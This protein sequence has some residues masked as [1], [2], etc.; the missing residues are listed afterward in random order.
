MI[1][2]NCGE[3]DSSNFSTELYIQLGDKSFDFD[4]PNY[5]PSW[6]DFCVTDLFVK[7]TNDP[8]PEYIVGLEGGITVYP[9]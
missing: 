6:V 4:C 2:I 3:P 5:S 9:N 8:L 7:I 1:T